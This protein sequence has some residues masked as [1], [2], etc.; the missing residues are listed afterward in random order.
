[1]TQLKNGRWLCVTTAFAPRTNS[2]LRISFSDDDCRNWSRLC[3]VKEAGRTL[4]NGELA[5]LE[6]GDVLLTMRSL[7]ASNSYRMPVYR[8]ADGGA[9]WAYLSNLDSSEGEAAKAGRG[10]WEPDF[11]L[12]SDNRLV[13]SYSD[14]THTGY[15][16]IVAQRLSTNNGATWGPLI[17]AVAE[18]GGGR[19]RPGMPQM[20]QMAN[21]LFLMVYEV[22]NKGNAD[23]LCKTSP[24]GISW[25]D[26]LGN[27]IPCHHCAPF[28]ASL[29]DGTLL[30]TSCENQVSFSQDFGQTWQLNEPAAWPG[31]FRFS[32]P[33][34]YLIKPDEVGVMAVTNGVKIRFGKI[35][36]KPAWPNPFNS[37]VDDGAKG[38]AVY[39]GEFS[40]SNGAFALLNAGTNGKALTGDISWSNGTFDADVKFLTAGNAGLLFRATN[41]DYRGP[42]SISG[43][44]A[45]LDAAG[46]AELGAENNSWTSLQ[47]ATL[48]V[49]TNVIHHLRVVLSGEEIGMFV[50][51]MSRPRLHSRDRQFTHGQIGLCALD[52]DAAFSN[53]TFSNADAPRSAPGKDAKENGPNKK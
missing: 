35:L 42:H 22:V 16:Q 1:M 29:P 14:E 21:G 7:I 11:Q 45:A 44:C 13:A 8:S 47:R 28:I 41:P 19:L 9:T 6:N 17:W 23:V 34:I 36:P 33:A 46:F 50:D 52:C 27:P 30:V 40:T 24:D 53:V 26:G 49:Q 5:A 51:D 20:T 2:W 32:W 12:L 39:G 15:S 43:Y 4:D 37:N 31:G 10:L 25:Q 48:S 18:P 3:Q 38:W